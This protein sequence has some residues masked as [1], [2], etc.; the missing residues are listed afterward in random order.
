[1]N[2]NSDDISYRWYFAQYCGVR[3]V[4]ASIYMRKLED[5][6]GGEG[7][8]MLISTCCGFGSTSFWEPVPADRYLSDN[9]IR[10][11]VKVKGKIRIRIKVKSWE[12][13]RLTLDP[14]RLILEPW[15]LTSEL[16]RQTLE[17]WRVVGHWLQIRITWLEEQDP[18]QDPDS[19][20]SKRSDSDR[21]QSEK[22]DPDR[23]P[24]EKP[25]PEFFIYSFLI[26][27]G[28]MTGYKIYLSF[29]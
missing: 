26:F 22:L 1:M 12:V 23:R 18:V 8:R 10:I 7:E 5:G 15:G 2:R 6:E 29:C 4:A 14:W 11:R 3:Y 21:R 27:G 13:W 19:H 20:H 9:R 25:D 17:P 24:R 16:R 28:P